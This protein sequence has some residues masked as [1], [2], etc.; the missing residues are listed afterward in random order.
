M[1]DTIKLDRTFI[2]DYLYT[3]YDEVEPMEFYKSIF[4]D[5]ELEETGKRIQGKYNAI[6]LELLPRENDE[7]ENVRKFLITDGLETL[8]KLL[9]S[10]NFII[11]SP[12]SYAGRSRQCENARFIYALAI[13]LD[14]IREESNLNDLFH[15]IE[16][17][18]LPK[19][20]YIVWSGTGLHL[21][22]QF[23]TPVPCF[24][25]I[26]NQLSILKKELTKKIWNKYISEL[27][28]KPQIESLFQGF[29]LVGGI[30]KG[31]NRT[32]CF[33]IGEKIDIEYLNSF[34][35]EEYRVKSFTYKSK[36][37][38]EE[39]KEKYPEWYKKRIVD[40]QKRGTWKANRAVYDWWLKLLK[41]KVS[42]GHRYYSVMV[43]SIYAKKCGID[44]AELEKD[45]FELVKLLDSLTIDEE[46]HF[47]REDILS[48]LEM[49]NDN[50]ITFPI[51]SIVS[52]TAIPIDKNKRNGRKQDI[53]L[54]IARST[55]EILRKEKMLKRD[56]RPSKK[57]EVIEWHIKNPDKK[58]KDCIIEI[59]VSE[60]TARKYWNM[61]END[62]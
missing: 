36:L 26:V 46:N 25:N 27:A 41:E 53:H 50:Y 32:K 3:Y 35:A 47:V 10:E 39:A 24:K 38:L 19:P 7:R 43:L 49:Y 58:I 14:G 21:Y 57:K 34:V 1:G 8:E 23:I 9:K 48:A 31:G 56:G 40:K 33:E 62:L 22:Y 60:N 2:R 29:R 15:Q 59:G 51:N 30:T 20:T 55:L 12:I 4:P 13:D 16:I 37:T 45:A 61:G 11:I 28:D 42:V 5:G 54:K 17:G 18:Y 52:L 6:A 44:K